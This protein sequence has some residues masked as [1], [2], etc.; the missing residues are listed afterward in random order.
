MFAFSSARLRTRR[1]SRLVAACTTGVLAVGAVALGPT[2]LAHADTAVPHGTKTTAPER[3]AAEPSLDLPKLGKTPTQALSQSTTT[4]AR[5]TTPRYDYDGDGISDFFVQKQGNGRPGDVGVWSSKNRKLVS[6]GPA[7]VQFRELIDPG[8]LTRDHSGNEVLGLTESGHLN[9][10]RGSDFTHASGLWT[11]PGWQVYNQVI[12]VGD[13]DGN[14]FGDLLARTPSGDLYLFKGNGETAPFAPRV[15][16]GTGWGIYDQL[17]GAGDITGTGQETLVARDLNGALWMF[18][19]NGKSATPIAPRVQIGTG[20]GIYNQIIGLGDDKNHQGQILGRTA[21]GALY[22]YAGQP[23][24]TGTHTLGARV[25]AGTGW[26]MHL[27]AGQGHAPV[28]GR[29]ILQGQNAAGTLYRYASL[30]NGK[31]GSR[32]QASDTGFFGNL[33]LFGSVSLTDSN[34]TPVLGI[35]EDTLFD[36]ANHTNNDGWGIYNLVNGPGDLNGDGKADLIAR[37]TSGVLW[38]QPGQGDGHY[39][40]RVRIGG[41][42]KAYNKITGSGDINGDGYNDIVARDGSGHLYLYQGTGKGSAPFKTRVYIGAGWNTYTKIASPGDL[43]GDGRADLVGVNST[44]V[45]YRYSGT[46]RTGTATFRS[47]VQIGTGWNTYVRLF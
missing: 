46:G 13:I 16:V 14:G 38:L 31:L 40:A 27:V 41:G 12:A 20:W 42:W 9:M 39:S 23:G 10:Y 24:G 35:F 2:T 45:L 1:R 30:D 19:L 44:G 28:Y 17:I 6:V 33:P 8:N 26:N 11:C 3:T 25:G 34:E 5:V 37:D 4:A 21:N 18:K 36:W 15:K 47:R 29:N 43:D 22:S 7:P 32:T